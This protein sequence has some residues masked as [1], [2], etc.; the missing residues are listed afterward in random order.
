MKKVA[1]AL[2]GYEMKQFKADKQG[3]VQCFDE[4]WAGKDV[5]V[6]VL[7]EPKEIE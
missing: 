3:H 1:I 2:E 4:A 5:A 7:E 6:I